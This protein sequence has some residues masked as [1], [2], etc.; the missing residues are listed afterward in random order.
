MYHM[1]KRH[2]IA[3][4]MAA[5]Y[6]LRGNVMYTNFTYSNIPLRH[7]IHEVEDPSGGAYNI[8]LVPSTGEKVSR[9]INTNEDDEE[10]DDIISSDDIN[11]TVK[12][13]TEQDTHLIA[14]RHLADYVFRPHAINN[15]SLYE[16]YSHF[17]RTKRQSSTPI[18]KCFLVGHPLSLSHSLS[19]R[20]KACI[21]VING[22]RL[23]HYDAIKTDSDSNPLEYDRYAQIA[24]IL[25]KPFRNSTEL[26]T[27]S[28]GMLTD[29]HSSYRS[30]IDKPHELGGCS[31]FCRQI[32]NNRH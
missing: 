32:L 3:G 27:T 17:Y 28:N 2:E 10:F 31:N 4:S 23:P 5:L 29:W 11:D 21:P 6:L 24:L 15:M 18:E 8:P 20:R 25:F 1:T 12:E 16:F 26:F 19:E 30:W 13:N 14:V 7:I 9:D 22:P